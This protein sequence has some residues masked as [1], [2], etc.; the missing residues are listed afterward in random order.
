MPRT[1]ETASTTPPPAAP[2]R[3]SADAILAKNLVIARLT[4][5][6]TQYELAQES[7]ISR[8]TIAQIETGSSD[9]RLSTIV[10]LA[11]ALAVP[12]LFLL[13]G[14]PEVTALA[15]ILNQTKKDRPAVDPRQ[16]TRMVRY[17]ASGMLKDRV[18][19]ALLGAKS[20]ESISNKELARVTAAIFSAFMPG[21]GTEIGAILGNLLAENHSDS[22]P[23]DAHGSPL[24]DRNS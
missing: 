5:G 11:N 16:I 18:R 24:K 21:A 7:G 13:I 6:V 3:E 23:G 10:E 2:R 15:E 1:E 20:V 4:K 14:L 19:A 9:P 17:I 8:A 22:R 12:P